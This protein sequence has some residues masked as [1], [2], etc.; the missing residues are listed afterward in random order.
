MSISLSPTATFDQPAEPTHGSSHGTMTP[1]RRVPREA[2]TGMIEREVFLAQPDEFYQPFFG[3]RVPTLHERLLFIEQA[4][5]NMT[6]L[7]IFEN[8]LYRVEIAYHSTV[9]QLTITRH[10]R[11]PCHEWRHFQQ[12]KNEL[13]GPEYEAVELFPAES[14]LVDTS[15]EYHLWVQ[16]TPGVRLPFGFPGRF[17]LAR[18]LSASLFAATTPAQPG[19]TSGT[20]RMAHA[21]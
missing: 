15:N 17:V 12:I 3:G 5:V 7:N 13:V 11:Q 16:P 8:E 10:D 9:I 4:L 1:F 20:D 2:L 6:S 19:T 21:G 14:R 18:P